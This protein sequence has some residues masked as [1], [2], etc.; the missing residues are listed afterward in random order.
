MLHQLITLCKPP[1]QCGDKLYR[2]AKSNPPNISVRG[3]AFITTPALQQWYQNKDKEWFQNLPAEQKYS[4]LYIDTGEFGGRGDIVSLPL[5][6]EMGVLFGGV[7][8]AQWDEMYEVH[9]DGVED[10]LKLS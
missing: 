5:P 1:S 7:Q 2:E 3:I 10:V 9:Q 4:H 6:H 8:M